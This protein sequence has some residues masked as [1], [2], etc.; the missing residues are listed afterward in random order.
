MHLQLVSDW[1]RLP[2]GHVMRDYPA[3]AG[4]LLIRQ[5]V[6]RV[7][8]DDSIASNRTNAPERTASVASG[9]ETTPQPSRG[10]QR[11]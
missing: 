9:G 2:A 11:S 10:R 4:E 3:G 5:G 6:A 8:A 1:R 7:F